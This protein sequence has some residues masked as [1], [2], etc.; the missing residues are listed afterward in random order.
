MAINIDITPILT[1]IATPSDALNLAF[2]QL[3]YTKYLD[4]ANVTEFTEL[5]TGVKC[6]AKIPFADK[7]K[8]YNFMKSKASL[9]SQCDFNECDVTTTFSVKEW[10]THAYNC[11][12]KLCKADLECDFQKWFNESGCNEADDL[13]D[14]FIQ[15]LVDWMGDALIDSHWVKVWFADS[16]VAPTSGLFG[17]DGLFVQA[18]AAAPVGAPNRIEILENAQTT[19]A[20]Q[21]ALA[22]QTGYEVFSAMYDAMLMNEQLLSMESGISILATKG[23]V[24][25][26]LQ[27]LRQNNQVDCCFK[28]DVT[29]GVYTLQNLNIFGV[30]IRIMNEWDEIIRGTYFT[31]LNDGTQWNAPHRAILTYK[32]NL[33]VGTCN[34]DTLD[35]VEVLY[36]PYDKN[37]SIRSEY[38]IGTTIMFDNELILAQ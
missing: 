5:Q 30:P 31:E 13:G 21:T 19:Y 14:N 10:D 23:L 28:N 1:Q 35:E 17:A 12:V 20:T 6:G 8:N 29:Q 9:T 26:Y 27:Y 24:V 16:S 11:E 3:I 22:A 7:G 34:A 32:E 4:S 36:N 37:I 33:Q 18:L 15:F 25:N 38:E 2:S